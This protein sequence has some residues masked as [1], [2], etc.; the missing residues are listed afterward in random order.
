MLGAGMIFSIIVIYIIVFFISILITRWIFRINDIV[1]EL[2]AIRGLL[3]KGA[4]TVTSASPEP[5]DAEP[6]GQIVG[7]AYCSNCYKAVEVLATNPGK[8]PVCGKNIA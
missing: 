8:C 2:K 3:Q 4:L 5:S 7:S 1:D 6:S